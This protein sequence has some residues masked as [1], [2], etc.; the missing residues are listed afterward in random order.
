M[1]EDGIDFLS[2]TCQEVIAR[3]ARRCR[4]EHPD[5]IDYITERYL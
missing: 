4:D 2:V 1:A 3:L 5:Y